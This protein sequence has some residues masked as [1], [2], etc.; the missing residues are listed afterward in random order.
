VLGSQGIKVIVCHILASFNDIPFIFVTDLS[1][2]EMYARDTG[3][4]NVKAYRNES[5]SYSAIM[6]SADV[7]S[8]LKS[9]EVNLSTSKSEFEVILIPPRTGTQAAI[10]ALARLSL[11]IERIE[12]FALIPTAP[13]IG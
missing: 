9:M 8:R 10:W 6:A 2:R 11:R 5:F 13:L 3:S 7:Y 4:M 1:E 12:G